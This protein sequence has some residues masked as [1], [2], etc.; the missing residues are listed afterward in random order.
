MY[1]EP[2]PKKSTGK[3]VAIVILTILLLLACAYIGYDKFY[4]TNTK[5]TKEVKKEEPEEREM[6]VSEEVKLT[7]NIN[8]YFFFAESFSIDDVKDIDNQTLLRFAIAKRD[9]QE[10]ITKQQLDEVI[11]K[12]F[13]TKVT[14]THE[15]V[16]CTIDNNVLYKYDEASGKYSPY[17]THGH[18]GGGYYS[19]EVHLISGKVEDKTYTLK[20]RIMYNNYCSDTCSFNNYYKS[21]E[22]AK[23]GKNPIINTETENKSYEDVKNLLPVT[24][25]TFIKEDNN[26][27]LKSIKIGE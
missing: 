12:Y 17:G 7:E 25:Y 6:Y 16:I 19:G 15:D 1:E 9:I 27:T 11:T 18:G 21:V 2:K 26:Y 14:L 5:D 8:D 3:T 4:L 10:D 13:G 20:T 24:T 22:D 23:D